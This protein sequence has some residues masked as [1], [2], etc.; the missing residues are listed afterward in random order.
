IIGVSL[1]YTSS[2]TRLWVPLPRGNHVSLSP[3]VS[4]IHL[5]TDIRTSLPKILSPHHRPIFPASIL[6]MIE[7]IMIEATKFSR[8]L[9]E[10]KAF[11]DAGDKGVAPGADVITEEDIAEYVKNCLS[12]SFIPS[13]RLQC[14]RVPKEDGGVVDERLR[15]YELINLEVVDASIIPIQLVAHS[16]ATVYA[17][18][19]K[20]ADLIKAD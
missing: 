7:G 4:R 8:R 20:A 19:E 16:Q 3:S 10:T 13:E 9:I 17:I 18:A 5:P 1:R 11:S 6:P 14:Y 12:T 15:V 2:R